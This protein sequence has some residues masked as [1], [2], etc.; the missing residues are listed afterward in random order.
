MWV[1]TVC[2]EMESSEAIWRLVSPRET[3]T[4]TSSSRGVSAA[5]SLPGR[6]ATGEAGQVSLRIRSTRWPARASWLAPLPTSLAKRPHPG[7]NVR[8]LDKGLIVCDLRAAR[9]HL[10]L[11]AAPRPLP[12]AGPL[13]VPCP[14]PRLRQPLSPGSRRCAA[15]L[16]LSGAISGSPRPAPVPVHGHPGSTPQGPNT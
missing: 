15:G 7:W 3:N 8:R 6:W 2:S 12:T 5:K 9:A 14:E 1:A 11:R 10:S 16:R 4:A 13:F